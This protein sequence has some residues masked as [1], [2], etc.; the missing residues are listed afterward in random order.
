MT[1]TEGA[2]GEGPAGGE[3]ADSGNWNL[4][5]RLEATAARLPAKAAL[6]TEAGDVTFRDLDERS[7]AVAGGLS[8][9]GVRAGDR[10]GIMGGSHAEFVVT[11]Y[12]AWKLG[13]IVV[14]VNTQLGLEEVRQ[15]LANC[16]PVVVVA[17]PGRS[18]EVVE[19]AGS[20]LKS[21]PRVVTMGEVDGP[22]LPAVRL[23][24]DADATIFYT[25]GTTGVP[26]G[27]THTHRAHRV[28]LEMVALRFALSE[29]DMMLSV[30]PIFLLSILVLGPLLSVHVGATCRLM[31]RYEA[32]GFARHVKGDHTTVM[33]ATIPMMFSDLHAL[34]ADQA[35]EVDLSSVRVASCGG[36]P[37]PPEIRRAFEQRYDFRFLHAY[38][39]TEG[40][41]TVS[42]DPLDRERKFD[43][44][45][46][47]LAHLLVT[48]EDDAGRRLAPGEIGEICT[49][50]LEEGPFAGWY[51]PM[52][53]YWGMPA[54]SAEAL[55]GGRLHWGDLGYLDEDGFVYLVDRKKD[56][57][58]RGGMN[59]YPKE[60]EKLLYADARIAECAVVGAGHAR[61][62]EVPWAFV[63]VAP[64][65]AIS[66][67]EVLALV[68]ERAARF[69]HLEGVTFTEDFPRN[70][71][72]KVLKRELRRDL[73]VLGG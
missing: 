37:M 41:A 43:S 7:S 30:L 65:T 18:R 32:L 61:Y 9:L 14:A 15:H 70:A 4:A 23:G 26:K 60:L 44:V 57:I 27:A 16:E 35:A 49:A 71:L 59:V 46:V 25:S 31:A 53:A 6:R 73:P 28:Q 58:I 11:V 33:G 2:S 54:E 39:G 67:E 52:R 3:L 64:G 45:G 21:T 50:P 12:G 20:G 72:G 34:P 40:P 1:G 24:P 56:M 36:S 68:S 69:K 48:V 8:E 38:G 42:T 10:V 19:Q 29:D 5:A 22:P 66:N 13:A 51:E 47:P 17:D 55:R 63:R 62:G